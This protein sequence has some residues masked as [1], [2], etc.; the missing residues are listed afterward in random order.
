MPFG[1][2][3]KESVEGKCRMKSRARKAF[4]RPG[5]DSRGDR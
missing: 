1:L 4:D 2:H 3:G 5:I